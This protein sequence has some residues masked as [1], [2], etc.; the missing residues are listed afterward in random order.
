MTTDTEA[1]LQRE[2]DALRARLE[3]ME[4]AQ[5]A[6]ARVG[7][8]LVG[9]VALTTAATVAYAASP[10]CA[11]GIPF[12]FQPDEPALASEVN[13]NFAQL[14]TW[15]ESKVGATGSVASPSVDVTTRAVR[16]SSY[17]PEYAGWGAV[18]T[19]P[20]GAA[21][22]NDNGVY[23]ALMVVGNSSAGGGR[24]VKVF[25]ELQVSGRVLSAGYQVS[26]AAG[27]SGYHF[28]FCCRMNIADGS[29]QCR[30]GT[31]TN[32]G[33]WQQDTFPF[34]AGSSGPYSLDCAGHRGAANWPICCRT[35]VAGG[36]ACVMSPVGGPLSWVAAASPW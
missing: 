27:E 36:T 18:A 16:A 11:N 2:L 9:V 10:V 13:T 34:A 31:N 32:F 6:R 24:V 4:R 22:V 26:C 28:G 33:G 25:D 23:K 7:R 29:T 17:S 8:W 21:I 19:G 14:K 15:L 3:A 30:N 5:R 35:D 1:Q 20:G 12:C